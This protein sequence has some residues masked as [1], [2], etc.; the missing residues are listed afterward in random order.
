MRLSHHD[1]INYQNWGYSDKIGPVYLNDR[2]DAISPKKKDEIEDEVRKYVTSHVG[3]IFRA[4]RPSI[5]SAHIHVLGC[6]RG[7]KVAGP[8]CDANACAP[9]D[10]SAPV[11][12]CGA[13][14]Y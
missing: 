11:L 1:V 4:R 6:E 14:A 8:G 13:I 3:C 5:F 10:I 7:R 9:A 12:P 2:E